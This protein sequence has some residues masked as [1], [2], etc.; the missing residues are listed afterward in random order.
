MKSISILLNHVLVTDWPLQK[1]CSCFDCLLLYQQH[2]EH[3][4]AIYSNLP[5]ARFS[6]IS[7]PNPSLVCVNNRRNQKL[8]STLL[9]II[10]SCAACIV[11]IQKN[12]ILRSWSCHRH[13]VWM[14]ASS[15]SIASGNSWILNLSPLC[16][17]LKDDGTIS[18]TCRKCRLDQFSKGRWMTQTVEL[19]VTMDVSCNSCTMSCRS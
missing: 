11:C 14:S 8:D 7:R 18:A 10:V 12:C 15:Q 9:C 19:S 1:Q 5:I 16:C 13:P 17:P 3:E 4:E 2:V 6:L